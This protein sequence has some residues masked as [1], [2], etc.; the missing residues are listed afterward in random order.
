MRM[1]VE[2]LNDSS[3]LSH[4]PRLGWLNLTLTETLHLRLGLIVILLVVQNP[5]LE[6]KAIFISLPEKL[7]LSVSVIIY[8][9]LK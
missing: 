3:I 5:V 9:L 4:V 8:L 2:R 1:I 7:K 6:P